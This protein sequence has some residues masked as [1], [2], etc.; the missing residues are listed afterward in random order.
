MKIRTVAYYTFLR[1]LRDYIAILA[2][3][4]FP[5]AITIILGADEG[6]FKPR[7]V[8]QVPV[9]YLNEDGGALGAAFDKLMTSD[10]TGKTFEVRKVEDADQGEEMVRSG[11]LDGFVH[12]P[13][14]ASNRLNLGDSVRLEYY[15]KGKGDSFQPMVESFIRSYNLNATLLRL[16][17]KS[18]DS[19]DSGELVR[20]DQVET[21]GKIPRAI[22]YY[23]ISF[24]LQA[25]LYGGLLGMF[26]I[27]KNNGNHSH[28]RLLAAPV[29]G[30]QV[31]LG[32]W[33]GSTGMLFLI[34]VIIFVTT[35]Y[36]Y[37]ANW[38][39]RIGLILTVLLLFCAV[40]AALG[41]II[42]YLTRST[43]V[44]SL[45]LVIVT[46]FFSVVAG[47]YSPME[48]KVMETISKFAPS[49]Y[50]Q[51]AL[52]ADIYDKGDLS[53]NLLGLLAYSFIVVFLAFLMGR[54]KAI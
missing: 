44:A 2:L 19:G 29:R 12:V 17:D 4:A 1:H 21:E 33:I 50:A 30:S 39:A 40:S 25:I 37:E 6:G 42:A 38:D 13:A 34:A 11:E 49:S 7:V 20:E 3:I 10:A 36:G 54:R 51:N 52:F 27:T 53:S 22:D 45:V 46:T 24:L 18:P 48:S 14:D 35:K 8:E 31:M 5:I 41:M 43:M 47:G 16:G 15:G 23:A 32:K 26:A 28:S 9:G